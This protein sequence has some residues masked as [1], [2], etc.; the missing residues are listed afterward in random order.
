MDTDLDVGFM[1]GDSLEPE[2]PPTPTQL[3]LEK[4]PDRPR[5]LL[6][7]SPSTKHEKRMRRRTA[8]VLQG[9][10][11][12]SLRFYPPAPDE[13]PDDE[14]LSQEESSAA[15]SEKRKT[16]KNLLV[17]L[18][19]LKEDVSDLTK[20]TEKIESDTNLEDDSRELDKIL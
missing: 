2:L 1:D 15:V 4:A 14:G 13:G 11:L 6:S 16:R 18:R 17:E 10:P 5:G 7:S 12:K 3:G 8:D 9:S 19:K 20:W